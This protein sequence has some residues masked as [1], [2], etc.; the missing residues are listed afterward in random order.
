MFF[1]LIFSSLITSLS[2]DIDLLQLNLSN[3]LPILLLFLHN[4]GHN[5]SQNSILEFSAD[6]LLINLDSLFQLDFSLKHT[7]FSSFVGDETVHHGLGDIGTGNNARNGDG[8]AG[9]GVGNI[10]LGLFSA[11]ERGVDDVGCG[12][13]EKIDAG[14]EGTV[15]GGL[16]YLI[17]ILVAGEGVVA[18]KDGGCKGLS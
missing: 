6:S 2:E 16:G 1:Y 5:N 7:D 8:V 11:G 10:D 13:A 17:G 9:A 15:V 18:A 12:G 14:C 3:T 4:L